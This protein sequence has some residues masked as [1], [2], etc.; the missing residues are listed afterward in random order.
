[1]VST[2]WHK[3][4]WATK[5]ASKA[6]I[7]SVGPTKLGRQQIAWNTHAVHVKHA[8]KALGLANVKKYRNWNI[9]QQFLCHVVG[10]WFPSGVYNIE[11]WQ[12]ALALGAI[13]NPWDRCNRTK[14]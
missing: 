4:G 12:P 6:Y 8:K 13:A 10:A 14:K 7:V 1:M 5:K 11:S 2:A 3:R 9:E